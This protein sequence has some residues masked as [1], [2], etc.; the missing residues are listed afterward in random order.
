MDL[1]VC[2]SLKDSLSKHFNGEVRV[3]SG[4]NYCIITLPLR[5]LDDR[6]IS[7][8]VEE[9]LS[10]YFV[11]HDGGKTD[12]ALFSQGIKLTEQKIKYQG[13]IAEQYGAQVLD[14]MIQRACRRK[15]LGS[16]ILSVAQSVMLATHEVLHHKP[17][18][19]DAPITSQV[20]K[21]L[22]AWKPS[23][24]ID[25][26]KSVRP[27]HDSTYL[28][29]YVAHARDG[30]DSCAVKIVPPTHPMWQ[31][32]RFGF[33][34]HEMN[35][36]AILKGWLRVAIVTRAETWPSKAMGIIERFASDIVAIET[37]HEREIPFL[38]PE[39]MNRVYKIAA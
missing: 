9:R 19:L 13:E 35:E 23:F 24:I 2:S 27:A 18:F 25:I 30:R 20:G 29:D 11:V 32:E 15:D 33:I 37:G 12:S 8:I 28:L 31:A 22:E 17:N 6:T 36:K 16:A 3:T 34:G 7:L 14:G 10:D 1:Q 26:Q 4:A 21:A 38:V 5:T 39:A